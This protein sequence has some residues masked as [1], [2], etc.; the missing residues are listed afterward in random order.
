MEVGMNKKH[1]RKGTEEAVLTLKPI[2]QREPKSFSYGNVIE[3]LEDRGLVTAPE[4]AAEL[5]R[6]P[7]EKIE[8]LSADVFDFIESQRTTRKVNEQLVSPFTSFASASMRGDSGCCQ[9]ECRTTKLTVLKHYAAMYADCVYC[10]MPVANPS[11]V[12]SRETIHDG[13]IQT[14]VSLLELRPLIE[15]GRVRPLVSTGHYCKKC[16]EH[17]VK[18]Y[19]SGMRTVKLQATKHLKDFQLSYRKP[20][21]DFPFFAIEIHGPSDYLEHGAIFRLFSE[22]PSWLPQPKRVGEKYQLRPTTAG[23]ANIV[24]SLFR[25]IAGDVLFHR[26]CSGVTTDA[27]YLTNLPGEVEFLG[28][29]SQGD[30]LAIRT[31]TVC[32]RLSHE[33][34]LLMD[35]PIRTVL[36]IREENHQ[37][38]DLY[39]TSIQKIVRDYI[40]TKRS[41]TEQEAREIYRDL[42]VPALSGLRAEA[43]RQ[44]SRWARKSVGLA[45]LALGAVTLGATG[46]LQSQQVLS[47]LGGAVVKGLFDQLAESG[48]EPVT[49]NNLYFLLRLEQERA[50]QE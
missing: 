36:K 38:F 25:D 43:K 42:L 19:K 3:L 40:Q 9:V 23:H 20:D 21:K 8:R 2:P 11:L 28:L 1:K 47:L 33:I 24:E 34:P 48:T 37:S 12:E 44:H 13:L 7:F 6:W 45:G 46:I 5:E 18:E 29:L 4:A 15:S 50:K 16:A 49:S 26:H 32:S 10:P 39:R 27:A 30:E 35:V 41:T 22:P 14:V 31:A 17:A